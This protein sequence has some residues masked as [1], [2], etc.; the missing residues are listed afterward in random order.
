L[1]SSR[2]VRVGHGAMVPDG[3]LRDTF[4]KL[5]RTTTS[6]NLPADRTQSSPMIV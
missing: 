5:G 2:H 3:R 1:L 4:G 6:R